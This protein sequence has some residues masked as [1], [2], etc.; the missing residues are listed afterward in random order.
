MIRTCDFDLGLFHAAHFRAAK[1]TCERRE[2]HESSEPTDA[3]HSERQLQKVRGPE[4]Y[5]PLY[6][7]RTA[8]WR[9]LNVRETRLASVKR[10]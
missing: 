8:A 3:V 4:A 7:A 5:R 9:T 6:G 1:N 2:I 10:V